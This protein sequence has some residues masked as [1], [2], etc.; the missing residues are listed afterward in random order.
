LS[1][2][3]YAA[4]LRIILQNEGG[5]VNNPKDPGGE[6]NYGITKRTAR[7][8]G[9]T[10]NMHD[11]P[12]SV[13]ERIYRESYWKGC[14]ALPAGVDLCVFDFAVNSGP[15]R[16]WGV[17]KTAKTINGICDE[18]LR[19]LR[20]LSTWATFGKG[21]AKRVEL[22][23]KKA[24]AMAAAPVVAPKPVEAP[25]PAAPVT[26][27]PVVPKAAPAAPKAQATIWSALGDILSNFFKSLHR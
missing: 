27:A 8:H 24:L 16:A 22:V 19:F 13:V 9:Y 12:M 18:R 14:D 1:T 6:T 4:C 15:G 26:P 3:N 20:G 5:Y 11:I 21:W 7:D 10:G 17:Y 25:K 23:R 2:E